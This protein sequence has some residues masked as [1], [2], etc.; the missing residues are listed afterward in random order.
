MEQLIGRSL[1]RYKIVSR[2]GE[3]GM[4]AVFKAHDVALLRDV[5][6]KVMHPHFAQQPDFQERFLQEARTAARLDHPGI[7]AVHDF[8]Q[9]PS[10]LYIVME[11]IPGDDLRKLLQDLKAAN[12]WIVLPEAI[13]L[14]RHVGLAL[15]YAHRRGVLH[16]DIKPANI[17]LKPEASEGLPYR[18]VITDLGLAKLAEG[19]LM[20]QEGMALGTPAYMSPEQ[21]IGQKTDARSD[22]YSLGILLYELAVG[23]LPFPIKTISDAIRYHT[24]ETPP[25]PRSVRPHLPQSVERV[26][27]KALAK[28]PADR[29]SDAKALADA[30]FGALA[31]EVA[32]AAPPTALGAAV[33]LMTQYQQSLVEARGPSI[34][35]EFPQV[36]TDLSRD[37]IQ[38]M[39]P[40]GAL[41][42]VLMKAQGLTIGRD[43]DND[44]VIDHPKVSRH[45]ARME[46]DGTNYRVIDLDSS[47]GTYLANVKLLPG[48][49]DVWT[50]D[51]PLRIGDSWL[52]LE[53]AQQPQPARS[54]LYR[55]DGT[56]VDA[57]RIHSSPGVGRVGVFMEMTQLSVTP[58]SS[59]TASVIILN[60]GPVVDHF[61]V[62]V[63][64]V[65]AGWAPALPPPI[66]LLPS[67]QQEMK[68][69]IQPPRSPQSRAGRYPL[70]I[71]V[72]SQD[73]PDQVAE[74]KVTLTVAA[75]SQ[76]S[77]D[78]RPQRIR[79]GQPAQVTVQNQG[80]TQEAFTLTWQD[81]ADELAFEPPQAQV[82][83][84]QGQAAVTGFRAVPRRRRWIGGEK[85][86]AVSI[87]VSSPAG[88]VQTHNSE[89]VS[90]G[91]IPVWV[92]PLLIFLCLLLAGAVA[93]L[94]G[95]RGEEA[96]RATET[97]VAN[98]T[99]ITFAAD[100]DGDG[101][102]NADE[103]SFGT[104]PDDP[105]SDD[106]GLLDGDEKKADSNPNAIDTDGDTFIDGNEV[107]RQPCP[108]SPT[109]RDTDG[110]GLL[111]QFDPDPCLPPT[112]TPTPSVTPTPT[113][114][115]TPTPTP[116][117]TATPTPTSTSTNTSAPAPTS[118]ST[119]TSTPT[120]PPSPTPTHTFTP[121]PT[122]TSH[123]PPVTHSTGLLDIPQTF[124]VDLDEGVIAAG[125]DSDIWFEAVTAI[126]RYV[127]SRNGATI[128]IVGTSSVGRDGCAAAPLSTSRIHVNN[129]PVGTYV[130]VRTNLGRY[131]QFR[132]NAPIGPSPGTL[133]IGYTTWE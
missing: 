89:V 28:S 117:G 99:A 52:R 54:A 12:K 8:G 57:S 17:M 125:A 48:V 114:T 104:K 7:V 119:S 98:Q 103:A 73:A 22:V 59:T 44:V 77:S 26:I 37:R 75:Y 31:T 123:P 105:D 109:Q 94:I 127:T 47:N 110:D 30:L 35:A 23:Q 80:N 60:Q 108:T 86:H 13:Q 63:T 50:P 116:T 25:A 112:L 61:Q 29:F 33:S 14:V 38:I 21:A 10:F 6:I 62:S 124:T 71:R 9:G 96:A 40:N 4:G 132:V 27:L 19:G 93:L 34:L 43:S 81:R 118:T 72:A 68:L 120:P 97:A 100:P 49:S 76:F 115:S 69:T 92:P 88:Q 18:P 101:L 58:G 2:L 56:L 16:R 90:R 91:L 65:P 24:K 130:C 95:N 79:A 70:T 85:T 32:I 129:L 128:A 64:G 15:D 126:E 53:R 11:F 83:V 3:G 82:T 84:A 45:H 113:A 42:S 87:Q 107:H 121:S 55:R 1:D 20:T 39:E 102:T 67:A 133:S 5:A 74:V 122:Y 66:Q 111:D 46:F 106:D 36:P 78:L 41:R 51:K 131:S